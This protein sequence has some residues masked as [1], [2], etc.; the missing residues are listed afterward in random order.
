MQH[1]RF[2]F[3]KS[4]MIMIYCA[5]SFIVLS[6]LPQERG[7][8]RRRMRKR[9]REIG[10]IAVAKNIRISVMGRV[11]RKSAF[12]HAQTVLSDSS[13]ACA[14]S[15]SSIFSPLIYYIASNDYVTGQRRP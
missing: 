15:Y 10:R 12:E 5:Y 3:L 11:K 2:L 14:K 6:L 1:F 4:C 8:R 9:G 7:T 13:C